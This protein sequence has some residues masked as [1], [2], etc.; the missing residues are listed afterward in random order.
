MTSLLDSGQIIKAAYDE[1]KNAHRAIF[2]SPLVPED[3]DKIDLAYISS[4]NGTGKLGM[5]IYRKLGDIVAVIQI[6]YDSSN[7]M[8]SVERI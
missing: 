4:G 5:V 3:Y 6:T 2:L 1:E 8:A 7:R